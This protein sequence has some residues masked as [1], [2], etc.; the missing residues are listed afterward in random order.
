MTTRIHSTRLRAGIVAC[1]FAFTGAACQPKPTKTPTPVGE[2]PA[3]TPEPNP[4]AVA[5]APAK[6]YPEPPAPSAAKPVNFPEVVSFT[7]ANGL[8]VYVVE[9][10]EVPVVSVQ[11]G[12]RAGSM[13]SEHVAGFTAAMLREGTK[14]RSKAKIDDAIEFVGSGISAGAGVHTTSVSARVL[15]SDTRL[16]LTLIADEVMNPVFPEDSL[17]KLKAQAKTSLGFAKSQPSILASTLFDM[18]TYPEG[19]PYGR[20]FATDA[21]IDGIASADIRK[22]H[23]TFYRSNNAFLVLA[24]DITRKEAEPLVKR[25]LGNWK[26]VA[27][28]ALPANPLNGYKQYDLP[29][30]LVIHL[31][32]RPGSAQS[33]IIVGNL[34]IARNHPDWAKLQVAN[35][36]LGDDASGRL[37]IDI[38]EKKGLA[39]GIGSSVSDGQAPGTF[40]IDTRTRTKSTGEMLAAIFGHIKRLRG[41]APSE[42][43]FTTVVAKM[44]GS[45][46]LEIETA[47]QIAGRLREALV[48]ELPP[49]Y[50]RAYRDQLAAVQVGDVKEVARKYVHPIPHVVVVGNA[51]KVEPQLKQVFP[52]AKI[53]KYDGELKKL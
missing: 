25:T 39:Y 43:E 47:D 26:P 48:Y 29:K 27:Q 19:H 22:F 5:A 41:E 34:A 9:N 49:D 17:A 4:D 3:P 36:I 12:I 1:A 16:A 10:H 24:G 7:L 44:V 33:E 6:Q 15:A 37:F 14:S 35:T 50:W 21:D 38:R 13:D 20:P 46:P 31:V 11:L 23:E 32:D 18:V 40:S 42:G 28:T 51:G 30:E 2:T 52:K 8:E 53:I 45:F